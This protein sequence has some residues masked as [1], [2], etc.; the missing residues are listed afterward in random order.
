MS[1]SLGG[2]WANLLSGLL[3][4]LAVLGIYKAG[5][6]AGKLDQLES[7]NEVLKEQAKV[8]PVRSHADAK[9]RVKK[10]REKD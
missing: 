6:N 3:K 10:Y 2:T 1:I 4:L 5:K 8:K 7:Q 9:L